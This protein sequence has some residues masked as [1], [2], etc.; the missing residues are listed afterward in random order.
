[1]T[2]RENLLVK[3]DASV[4]AADVARDDL[5]LRLLKAVGS[6]LEG[7]DTAAIERNLRLIDLHVAA[8]Y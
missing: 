6:A 8:R 2:K 4:R 5:D 3:R 7:C 1:M